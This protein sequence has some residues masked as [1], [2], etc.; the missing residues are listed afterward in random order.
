VS[1]DCLRLLKPLSKLNEKEKETQS[2]GASVPGLTTKESRKCRLPEQWP[3]EVCEG[4]TQWDG[5][6]VPEGE[7][8]K[9]MEAEW[10]M[11]GRRLGVARTEYLRLGHL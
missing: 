2:P 7:P 8:K 6:G 11:W 10:L 5:T 4:D 9:M 3:H 1:Q